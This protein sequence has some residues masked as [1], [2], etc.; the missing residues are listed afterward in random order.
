MPVAATGCSPTVAASGDCQPGGTKLGSCSTGQCLLVS[1]EHALVCAPRCVCSLYNTALYPKHC[2]F[3]QVYAGYGIRRD[4]SDA[5]KPASLDLAGGH[6]L[7]HTQLQQQ[8][9]ADPI[10]AAAAGVGVSISSQ[11]S[12]SSSGRGVQQGCVPVELPLMRQAIAWQLC[13]RQLMHEQIR[14]AADFLK[15]E[16]KADDVR[17]L[18]V[19]ILSRL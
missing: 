1:A 4:L 19:G 5:A 16:M 10:A 18:Q 12:R 9:Y 17:G 2:N 3:P 6:A 11:S 13:H 7:S 15:R 8:Q 14:A